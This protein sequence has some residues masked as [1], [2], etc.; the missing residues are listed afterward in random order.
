MIKLAGNIFG[1][2]IGWAT[3]LAVTILVNAG[4]WSEAASAF[5]LNMGISAAVFAIFG[6]GN[7]GLWIGFGCAIISLLN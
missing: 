1:F 7:I 4:Q 3:G 6:M 5:A 2:V